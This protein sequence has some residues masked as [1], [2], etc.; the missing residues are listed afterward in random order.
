MNVAKVSHMVSGFTKAYS[1]H[2]PMPPITP[3]NA[4]VWAEV[5][6]PRGKGLARVRL[7]TA[8]IF[9]STRQFTAAAAPATSQMPVV[10]ASRSFGGTM[11][12]VARNMPITAQNTMSDTTRGLVRLRNWRRRKPAG[13]E[14]SCILG[15]WEDSLILSRSLRCSS[16]CA[17]LGAGARGF[18]A[19]RGSIS[20]SDPRPCRLALQVVVAPF[21]LIAGCL[22]GDV[23]AAGALEIQ[24]RL[25]RRPGH[26]D[27]DQERDDG[28]D[29]LDGDVLVEMLGLM[30]DGLSVSVDRIEHHA[31]HADKDHQDDHHHDEVQVVDFA[32]DARHRGRQVPPIRRLRG[33]GQSEE[34]SAGCVDHPV[35]HHVLV[36][37]STFMI[38]LPSTVVRGSL[39]QACP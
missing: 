17:T 9:C 5:S 1:V 19:R 13:T 11:P 6:S 4:R 38:R 30:A 23:R 39:F 37:N 26:G 35:R 21:P 2:S 24:D 28:P 27:Q 12:G 22:D 15:E 3:A 31:K 10:A 14:V 34:R 16:R 8:S 32:G 29:D 7:M 18:S 33:P 20:C 25:D 36:S